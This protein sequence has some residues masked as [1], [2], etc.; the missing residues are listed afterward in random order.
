MKTDGGTFK[1]Y[2]KGCFYGISW[3]N[4]IYNLQELVR[5]RV[6]EKSLLNFFP[7]LTFYVTSYIID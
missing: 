2:Y 6:L 4:V 5:Y 1:I 3:T 7:M